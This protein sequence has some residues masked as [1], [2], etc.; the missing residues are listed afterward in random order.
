[1]SGD[2]NQRRR[3]DHKSQSDSLPRGE[4]AQRLSSQGNMPDPN[5]A[6]TKGGPQPLALSFYDL[7]EA[8]ISKA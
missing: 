5:V 8:S 6:L 2:V 7:P 3:H 4:A 1:M